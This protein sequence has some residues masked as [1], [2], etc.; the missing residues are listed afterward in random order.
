MFH[1]Q[2]QLGDSYRTRY[3]CLH[4]RLE[5]YNNEMKSMIGNRLLHIILKR[6]STNVDPWITMPTEHMYKASIYGHPQ[7]ERHC[8]QKEQAKTNEISKRVQVVQVHNTA[9]L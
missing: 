7:A 9:G 8:S 5:N 2:P 4:S 3:Y 1:E 6:L